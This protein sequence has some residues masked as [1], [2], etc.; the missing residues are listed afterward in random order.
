[1]H[2]RFDAALAAVHSSR[3]RTHDLFI[4]GARR[5]GDTLST[6]HQPDRREL[7]LGEFA[8]ANASDADAAMQAAHDGLSGWRSYIDRASVRACCDA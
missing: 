6:P 4:N 3:G 5:P 7:H 2:E 8:V 1:M